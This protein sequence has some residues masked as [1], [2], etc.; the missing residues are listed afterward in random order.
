M[1]LLLFW[2]KKRI[3]VDVKAVNNNIKRTSNGAERKLT[4]E[5]WL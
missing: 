5:L 4:L 2:I 1:F 3:D